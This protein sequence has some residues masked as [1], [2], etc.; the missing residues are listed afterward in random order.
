MRNVVLMLIAVTML[1]VGAVSADTMIGVAPGLVYFEI[2]DPDGET[3][4]ITGGMPLALAFVH[5]LNNKTRIYTKLKYIDADVDASTSQIGQDVTGYQVVSSWQHVI[6]FSHEF[7]FYAGIG[8]GF[9]Q[10]DFKNRH[11]VDVDGFLATRYADRDEQFFSVVANLSQE[12]EMTQKINLGIDLS[13]QH[14]MGDGL[15]GFEAA[16]TCFYRF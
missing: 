6:K 12:W 7:Q 8:L 1:S 3:D 4:D 14:D 13:Y 11:T 2:D 9:T 5:D 10:A 15:S 16:L